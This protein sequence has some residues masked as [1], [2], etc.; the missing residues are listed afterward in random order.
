MKYHLNA[1][2]MNDR[3]ECEIDKNGVGEKSE[4]ERAN[5]KNIL[6]TVKYTIKRLPSPLYD[7]RFLNCCIQGADSG[8]IVERTMNALRKRKSEIHCE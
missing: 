2:S 6:Y 5:I 8:D 1:E 3:L 4:R 7:M